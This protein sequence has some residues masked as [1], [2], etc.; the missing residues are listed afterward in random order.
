MKI[1]YYTLLLLLFTSGLNAQI[2]DYR[3]IGAAHQIT[4]SFTADFYL[5]ELV[6]ER[7]FQ[8]NLG[9]VN[10]GEDRSEK[11]P[12]I[13]EC[14]FL[15]EILQRM[16][17]WIE[18]PDSGAV[19]VV[20]KLRRLYLW[21]HC[22]LDRGYVYLEMAFQPQG[23]REERTVRIR[24]D[25]K[26]LLVGRGHA[27]RLEAALHRSL[28]AYN[29]LRLTGGTIAGL[30]DD[31][32]YSE[33]RWMGA[34]SFLDLRE[35]RFKPLRARPRPLTVEGI[36]HLHFRNKQHAEHYALVHRGNWF[37]KAS[38]Y[39]GED[40]HYV[41]VLERGRYLFL[42][43]QPT[44]SSIFG[45]PVGNGGGAEK[46]GILID[47]ETGLPKV[48]TDELMQELMEPHPDLQR[49]F[50]FKDILRYP[51]QLNRVRL[52]IAE[53]NRRAENS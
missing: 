47:M 5:Q 15:D 11:R 27:P 50:L 40:N 33:S 52:V 22:D 51:I 29:E 39:F 24:L 30:Q 28:Q 45:V 14:G 19:G 44:V 20:A 26:E 4:A 38:S 13:P 49:K 2:P 17:G 16:N 12:L 9:F 10:R 48:V 35:A 8:S 34:E 36:P 23:E 46:V 42:I 37:I 41:Q 6:D 25:G 32:E 43:D 31:Y 18:R 53:I 21:E 3:I 7:S 1:F